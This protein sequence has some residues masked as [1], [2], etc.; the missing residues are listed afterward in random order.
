MLYKDGRVYKGNWKDDKFEGRGILKTGPGR[1][2]VV[3]GSFENGKLVPS[4][5]RVEY[6]NG[7]LFEGKMTSHYK[8]E[9][10][11]G[12]FYFTNGDRYFGDW[13]DDKREG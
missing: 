7:E 5:V 9:G 4:T 11:A 12:K 6:P 8:R 1:S 2:L 13:V 3:E 10:D